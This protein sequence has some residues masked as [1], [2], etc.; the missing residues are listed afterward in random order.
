MEVLGA[1]RHSGVPVGIIPAGT[2]NLLA[3]ALQIPLNVDR[4]VK[5]L[6][7][8]SKRA[9]DLGSIKGD[10][11]QTFAFAAG[12]GIDVTM[13]QRTTPSAK[14]R[15]G[16]LAYAMVAAT[17]A[18]RL[19]RFRVTIVTENERI[20][21][22]ASLTLVANFGAVLHGWFALGPRIA[23]DDG[24]LD[25]CVYAPRS[26]IDGVGMVWRMLRG[27]YGGDSRMYF[28]RARQVVIECDPPRIFQADGEI[29]GRSP[30]HISVDAGAATLLV[31]KSKSD[32]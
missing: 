30:V 5:S 24:Y 21:R 26:G 19:D 4:A 20:E 27:R 10:Q 3:R 1:L 16:V 31:P 17:A 7:H 8:G 32:A 13:I 2:G 6:V 29:L 18:L 15:F 12:V 25:V 11:L 14:R 9:I 22:D 28:A 23:P